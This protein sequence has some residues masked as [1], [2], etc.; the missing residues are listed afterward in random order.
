MITSG[1]YVFH[2][3]IVTL[4]PNPN[5]PLF[6]NAAFDV[7]ALATSA[8]GLRALNDILSGLPAD[9]PAAIVIVQHLHPHAPSL[10]P[11]ILAR[12]TP[13]SVKQAKAG[14]KLH[15]GTVYVAPPDWHLLVNPD[16]TFDLTHTERIHFTRPSADILFKSIANSCQHRAIAVVLTGSGKDGA[17]GIKAVKQMGGITIVQDKTTAEFPGMPVAATQTEAVDLILPLEQ[18]PV[19]LI[20]LVMS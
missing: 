1:S 14:E 16:G 4:S 10:L 11:Q 8:G 2:P 7:V 12:S 18:I 13:L 3:T 17:M 6:P 5:L 20:R 9:F 15:P 19:T